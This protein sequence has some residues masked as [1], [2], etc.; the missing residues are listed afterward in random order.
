MQV[1]IPQGVYDKIMHWINSTDIE[2]SGFGKVKRD[3]ETG[4]FEVVDAY[5]LKQEG[6]AA[7][8]DIDAS[9]L[10]KLMYTSKDVE[11]ELKWWWHSHVKMNCFW[12]TTDMDTI[13]EL[14]E[15]GWIVATVFN[16]KYE[17]KSALAY[18]TTSDFGDDVSVYPDI[19]TQVY[20]VFDE[21]LEAQWDAEFKANVTEKRYVPPTV[22][23]LINP[24][25]LS[26]A[27]LE[28]I[29]GK[30]YV[31][32]GKLEP[33]TGTGTSTSGGDD[34]G[35]Y[36][37][38]DGDGLLGYGVRNEAKALGMTPEAYLKKINSRERAIIDALEDKLVYLE[39]Q[40]KMDKYANMYYS[41]KGLRV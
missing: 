35:G 12:S 26:E 27:Q 36:K 41:T 29:Y 9:S 33:L 24:P 30:E 6:G 7:H 23:S 1:T 40:G 22:G 8:T 34:E 11:G 28:K 5:L 31:D 4:E 21:S 37:I 15:Q 20:R 18:K 16:Q 13:K 38:D 3:K 17:Y 39:Y 2:V 32:T 19:G 14:G 25:H 10:G